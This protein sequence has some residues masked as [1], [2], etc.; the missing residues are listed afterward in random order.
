VTTRSLGILALAV[1]AVLAAPARAAEFRQGVDV[2]PGGKLVVE[3]AVG[4]L[5]VETHDGARV[6]VEATSPDWPAMHFEL[7]GDGENA[8]LVGTRSFWPIFGGVRVRVRIPREYSLDLETGGGPIE[9]DSVRGA[10]RAQTS[11]GSIDLDGATGNVDLHTSGGPIRASDLHGSASLRTSGGPIT[12]SGVAGRIE[13]QTS[14]GAIR[15]S[16]LEGEVD[17]ET[18]GGAITARFVSAPAGKLHTSGGGIDVELPAGSGA[19]LEAHT[20][21]GRIAIDQSLAFTGERDGAEVRGRLGAGGKPLVLETSGG[22]I[23][24]RA[25]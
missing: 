18:S 20:S 2:R 13:A 23:S 8:R 3:L 14:G 24:I 11:G 22:N 9:I 17:A 21:G 6:E 12:A 15:L 19:Q 1:L 5:V 25:R 16:E 7:T 4:A 10:V